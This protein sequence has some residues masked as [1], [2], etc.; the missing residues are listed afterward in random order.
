MT[1]QWYEPLSFSEWLKRAFSF[2]NIAVFMITAMFLISE[3]RFDW[4]ENLVGSYLA[5]TNDSRPKTGVIWETGK[6]TSNAHEY[7]NK[8]INKKEDTQTNVHQ[9]TSFSSLVSGILPGEWVTLEKDHFKTLYL[10]LDKSSATK[11]IDPAQ[12]VYLLKGSMLDRI[13]CEGIAN[14]INIYFIDSE[15]RVIKQ[16]EI[17]NQDILEIENGEQAIAGEL[18]DMEGFLGRIYPAEIFFDA[19]FK[20]PPDILPDLMVNPEIL[21][22]Q[23]GKI[24][25]IGI[26]NVTQNGYIKLGFEFE[27][28]GD[29]QI[30]F[31][32]GREWAVWQLSLYLRGDEN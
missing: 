16:I 27:Q 15:N 28:Q 5:S 3:L 19:V 18:S 9:A 2:L 32:K 12:L 26:W 31:V 29:R 10:T 4:F 24:I 21:L 14:G 7:L 25:N 8:I 22:A 30:I 17:E 11:V 13:F 6:H 1:R 23:T 20:L